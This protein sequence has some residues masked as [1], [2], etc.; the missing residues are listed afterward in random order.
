MQQLQ[1]EKLL[2]R[3]VFVLEERLLKNAVSGGRLRPLAFVCYSYSY[4]SCPL[5]YVFHSSEL[6]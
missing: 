6:D 5:F 1:K 4:K 2:G 3:Y